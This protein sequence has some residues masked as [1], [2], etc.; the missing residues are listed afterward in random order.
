MEAAAAEAARVAAAAEAERAAAAAA[1]EHEL[2]NGEVT[3]RYNHYKQTFPM[4]NGTITASEIDEHFSLSFAFP[5]AQYHLTVEQPKAYDDFEHPLCPESG[6]GVFTGLFA[7]GVYWVLIE[8]DDEEAKKAA[9][10]QKEFVERM[11]RERKEKEQGALKVV[12]DPCDFF[13]L[14]F[15][16]SFSRSFSLSFFLSCFLSFLSFSFTLTHTLIVIFFALMLLFVVIVFCLFLCHAFNTLP[17]TITQ[18]EKLESCSCIEGNP[19]ASPY[20]CQDW[21]NRYDVAKKNGWKG[22]A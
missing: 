8:E 14:S 2:R 17:L 6:P 11:E 20:N 12:L 7:G 16:P 13:F 9:Q 18:V 3:L 4:K 1:R 5:N 22:H 21:K 19:C 15:F 10:R